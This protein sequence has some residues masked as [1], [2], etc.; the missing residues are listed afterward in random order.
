[1][2]VGPVRLGMFD[3]GTIVWT[4]GPAM[5]NVIVSGPGRALAALTALRSDP[6]PASLVLVTTRSAAV[7]GATGSGASPSAK[8]LSCVAPAPTLPR[9]VAVPVVRLIW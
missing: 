5:L 1:M 9:S 7:A 8:P 2:V 6:G 4:P 3:A